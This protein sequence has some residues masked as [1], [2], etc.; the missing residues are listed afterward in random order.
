MPVKQP[1]ILI[2]APREAESYAAM[3]R[4]AGYTNV[5]VAS[6]AQEAEQRLVGVE[7]VFGWRFPTHLLAAPAAASVRWFQSM[8]AGVDDL[9]ADDH[10]PAH[11]QISRI[12]DAFGRQIAEYVF[13][14]LLSLT[15][16]LPRMARAQAAGLW[17][18]FL[19]ATLEGKVMGVAG[20]GSIGAEI[21]R[22]ARAFDLRVHGLSLSGRQ[23][24]LVD[25]HYFPP[26]WTDFVRG[27]D[28]L[29]LALPATAQTRHRVDA[30][31][32]EALPDHAVLVNIGRGVVIDEA[33]LVSTLQRGHLH[34]AVLDVFEHEPL[35][36]DSPLW[37]LPGVRVTPHL[38]GPSTPSG[39]GRFFLENVNRYLAEEP[40]Q[41]LVNRGNGY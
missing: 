19:T 24:K 21:V 31:V 4:A 39:V 10:I 13:A 17:D 40:L 9:M 29:V 16:E 11:I 20:L 25:Q 5:S 41:G 1:H 28:V 34:A 32:L 6:R 23:A 30:M 36:G 3:L 33:A 26:A 7:I 12:V 15:K 2:Y 18:P 37:Q 35:T 8:G 22:K 27:L 38:S 14:H